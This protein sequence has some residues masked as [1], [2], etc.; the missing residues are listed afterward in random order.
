MRSTAP[1]WGTRVE[2]GV[3]LASRGYA[4][5]P[6]SSVVAVRQRYD[7]SWLWAMRI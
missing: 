2:P 1:P 5:S 4:R 3:G 7:S 6:K